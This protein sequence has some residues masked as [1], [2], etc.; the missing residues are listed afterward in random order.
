MSDLSL[1]DSREAMDIISEKDK[2]IADLKRQL[3]EVKSRNVG[4]ENC[5]KNQDSA[6]RK[7]GSLVVSP[8]STASSDIVSTQEIED[9]IDDVYRKIKRMEDIDSELSGYKR[10]FGMGGRFSLKG[11]LELNKPQRY[12][13]TNSKDK[14]FSDKGRTPGNDSDTRK[15]NLGGKVKEA[16]GQIFAS[17]RAF[18]QIAKEQPIN[19]KILNKRLEQLREERD[20]L[21]DILKQYE[22]VIEQISHE[23][24]KLK[25]NGENPNRFEIEATLTLQD[26]IKDEKEKKELLYHVDELRKCLEDIKKQKARKKQKENEKREYPVDFNALKA[27]IDKLE[28]QSYLIDGQE[29]VVEPMNSEMFRQQGRNEHGRNPNEQGMRQNLENADGRY[30]GRDERQPERVREGGWRQQPITQYEGV[31]NGFNEG[32]KENMGYYNIPRRS[33]L[34]AEKPGVI[35]ETEA[36]DGN[37]VTKVLSNRIKELENEDKKKNDKIMELQNKLNLTENEN[38]D[39]EKE[40]DNFM[41]KTKELVEL[42]KPVGSKGEIFPRQVEKGRDDVMG[43]V[44][45][46]ENCIKNLAEEN[47]NLKINVDEFE[48]KYWKILKELGQEKDAREELEKTVEDLNK[49][50]EKNCRKIEELQNEVGQMN[51]GIE[52]LEKCI[53]IEQDKVGMLESNLAACED[54]LKSEKE[55]SALFKNMIQEKEKAKERLQNELKMINSKYEDLNATCL[56]LQDNLK[57]E[58]TMKEDLKSK[59]KQLEQEALGLQSEID[60][61]LKEMED[62]RH[63]LRRTQ[64]DLLEALKYKP[65]LD[66]AKKKNVILRQKEDRLEKEMKDVRRKLDEVLSENDG[67]MKE[68]KAKDIELE[69]LNGDL[70]GMKEDNK[71]FMNKICSMEKELNAGKSQ[72]TEYENEIKKMQ[73]KVNERNEELIQNQKELGK[74]RAKVNKSKEELKEKNDTIKKVRKDKDDIKHQNNELKDEIRRLYDENEFHKGKAEEGSE[75]LRILEMEL[76]SLRMLTE[77]LEAEKNDFLEK[78]KAE[79]EENAELQNAKE[80]LTRKNK[81][82]EMA[83]NCE[84]EKILNK[85]KQLLEADKLINDKNNILNE[86]ANDMKKVENENEKLA[87]KIKAENLEK[88]R[89]EEEREKLEDQLILSKNEFNGLQKSLEKSWKDKGNIQQI[90][91]KHIEENKILHDELI[92]LENA[93]QMKDEKIDD[94]E[95]ENSENQETISELDKT[96]DLLKNDL[97]DTREKLRRKEEKV[98]E[99]DRKIFERDDKLAKF[100][101]KND[102]LLE[103]IAKKNEEIDQLRQQVKEIKDENFVKDSEMGKLKLNIDHLESKHLAEM[104]EKDQK[105][106]LFEEYNKSLKKQLDGHKKREQ[107]LQANGSLMKEEVNKLTDELVKAKV[108][109]KDFQAT[110]M[111]KDNDL[112]KINDAVMLL[113]NAYATRQAGLQKQMHTMQDELEMAAKESRDLAKKLMM[114][115]NEVD[116]LQNEVE[117][118]LERLRN[119]EEVI[120][121]MQKDNDKLEQSILRIKR[122]LVEGGQRL[123]RKEHEVNELRSKLANDGKEVEELIDQLE[124]TLRNVKEQLKSVEDE[125]ANMKDMMQDDVMKIQELEVLINEMKQDIQQRDEDVML[126]KAKRNDLERQIED[127]TKEKE[128]RKMIEELKTELFKLGREKQFAVVKLTKERD[129]ALLQKT[130]EK[131]A[132]DNMKVQMKNLKEEIENLKKRK[133]EKSSEHEKYVAQL[134]RMLGESR[135]RE[136]DAVAKEGE[137]KLRLKE[138]SGTVRV[139]ERRIEDAVVQAE[140]EKKRREEILGQL[141]KPLEAVEK[142]ISNKESIDSD[143]WRKRATNL[144]SN[145]ED[146][147]EQFAKYKHKAMADNEATK[148]RLDNAKNEE[149]ASLK[150]ELAEANRDRSFMQNRFRELTV[151][152]SA[153]DNRRLKSSQEN[154]RLAEELRLAKQE[155]MIQKHELDWLRNAV[156]KYGTATVK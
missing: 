154:N 29:P 110:L 99:M 148:T 100:Y 135:E 144:Q 8:R 54:D 137:Y 86:L 26:K 111:D 61:T 126:E 46:L 2:K 3:K 64:Q 140:E 90:L 47:L 77:T 81:D 112:N 98:L 146:L 138:M 24:L 142:E 83:L 18:R 109:L 132:K 104:K 11:E 125:K 44:K 147:K 9:V 106:Q 58:K 7:I 80:M 32:V 88:K 97:E 51:K 129:D 130:A 78:L 128:D 113:E 42:C 49:K 136:K 56:D 118:L 82:L 91:G 120:V 76:R 59:E 73:M 156:G 68:V 38:Y 53:N 63:S 4:L 40:R 84:K 155:A 139:L 60:L 52:E 57:T 27:R 85:E 45:D 66:D 70:D 134:K 96:V 55:N 43:L 121:H 95:E 37:H 30:R 31:P 6:V 16:E 79:E 20:N 133:H 149:I 10:G 22:P 150:M 116:K 127:K 87:A 71:K 72:I 108:I 33:S 74:E 89:L 13:N 39:L 114:K 23:D 145:I 119:E 50:D 152:L 102:S 75:A 151:E 92:K 62:L 25:R 41:Q 14:A 131:L 48:Q 94:L 19:D 93:A 28:K 36:G 123:G 107:K 67:R 21:Y 117:N 12:E 124:A 141:L 115:E 105:W 35:N 103:N 1:D 122:A 101:E 5:V 143:K 69:E 153:L 15:H 17:E 65:M 34:V